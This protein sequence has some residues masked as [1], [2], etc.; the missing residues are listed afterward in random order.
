MHACMH[1]GLSRSL[2]GGQMQRARTVS[3]RLALMR[4]PAKATIWLRM[5]STALRPAHV[6]GT[7]SGTF[8]GSGDSSANCNCSRCAHT[9]VSITDGAY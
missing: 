7:T 5:A 3:K 1:A 4:C 8:S 6:M 2:R 9:D